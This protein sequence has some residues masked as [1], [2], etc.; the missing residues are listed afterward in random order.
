MNNFFLK[1]EQKIINKF[2]KD[3][4]IIFDIKKKKKLNKIKKKIL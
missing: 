1:N 3:G 2:N 4:Y